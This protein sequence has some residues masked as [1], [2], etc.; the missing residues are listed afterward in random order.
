[1]NKT[2]KGALAASAAAVLLLGGAG[3][4]AYW[5]DA[6]T[7]QGGDVTAATCRWTPRRATRRGSTPRARPAPAAPSCV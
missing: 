5:S 1:M 7:I 6:E 3:S 4:L 2:T